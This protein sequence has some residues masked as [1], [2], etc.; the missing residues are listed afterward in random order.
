MD[1]TSSE[2]DMIPDS[3]EFSSVSEDIELEVGTASTQTSDF[4]AAV[5]SQK[6]PSLHNKEAEVPEANAEA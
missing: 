5:S 6:D 1:P 2:V 3:A 4:E